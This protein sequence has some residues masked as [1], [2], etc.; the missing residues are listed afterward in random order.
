MIQERS[1][2][3][4]DMWSIGVIAYSILA[5]YS[6]FRSDSLDDLIEEC[7][8]AGIVFHERYWKDISNSAK[9]FILQLLRP[10]PED[11]FT[12]M[13]AKSH[14]WI[15]GK[16]KTRGRI[17]VLRFAVPPKQE[18]C[19]S[20]SV[21]VPPKPEECDSESDDDDDMLKY[22]DTEI[23]KAEAELYKLSHLEKAKLP[24]HV[25]ARYAALSLGA[26]VK[27]VEEDEGLLNMVKELP[28]AA[29]RPQPGTVD[30]STPAEYEPLTI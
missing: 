28:E 7:T 15:T 13:A 29:N 22:F 8:Q 21:V 10:K 19:E 17:E 16:K 6:P 12:I 27:I 24:T 11:R 2:K 9:D 14:P 20:E 30:E 18:E 23:E 1:G 26:A 4:A 3:P 25:M 5:G